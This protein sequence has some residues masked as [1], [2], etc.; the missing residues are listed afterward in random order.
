MPAIDNIKLRRGTSGQW[1][2]ADPVLA[3]GEPGFDTTNNLMKVGNG[4]DPWSLL[5]VF[6]LANPIILSSASAFANKITIRSP[7]VNFKQVA[8]TNMFEVPNGHMFSID[9]F[10]ILTT[11]ISNPNSPPVIRFGTTTLPAE[12]YAATQV[13]SNS[14]GAR[15][16]I[17]NPQDAATA[18]T[19]ISFGVT[20]A[21]TASAHSG[22]AIVK[23]Y[24]FKT[25]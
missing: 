18:G 16:I 9:S 14:V 12:Y 19:I 15:H 5:S 2:F 10:E 1:S 22:C 21:S 13:T 4:R 25:S 24:L 7:I 20:N 17:D 23:G 11:E 8:D 3:E 6:A